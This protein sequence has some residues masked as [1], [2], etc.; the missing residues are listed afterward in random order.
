MDKKLEKLE[1]DSRARN[2]KFFNV[3]EG[4]STNDSDCVRQVIQLLNRFYPS[5][6][7]T[8]DD[9]D[10]AARIKGI[11]Q[12]AK[13][14]RVQMSVDREA[15]TITVS[16]FKKDVNQT[17]MDVKEIFR[18]AKDDEQEEK[19]K[20][21]YDKYAQ[22]GRLLEEKD[23]GTEWKKY[24]RENNCK[25][26]E[27]FQEKNKTVTIC[28]HRNQTYVI[29]FEDMVEYPTANQDNKVHVLR[30]VNVQDKHEVQMPET[31]EQHS[32]KDMTKFVP[33]QPTS[34]EFATVAT[35]FMATIGDRQMTI[36]EITR[37]QNQVLYQ[38]YQLK[39]MQM[40]TQNHAVADVCNERLLWHGTAKNATDNINNYGFNRS[41]CGKNATVHGQGVYFAKTSHYS[42]RELY[43]PKDEDGKRYMYQ[44]KI[45]VGVSCLGDQSMRVLPAR[46]GNVM[47]DSACDDV[48]DPGIY[49]I[50]LDMQ[51]YP[52]YLIT[53]KNA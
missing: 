43:S 9:V 4:R 12:V 26:E 17:L 33:L 25:I 38:Q 18:K 48:S 27:A 2:V 30:R 52:E 47:Y 49:V 40:E 11:Q 50:F 5:K 15:G 32:P 41:Y 46:D 8:T 14:K 13:N 44:S 10:K 34:L 19:R 3:F 28:N 53:F 1:T 7:W 39:K 22:W 6:A 21:I 36:V 45:L 31:W 23:K 20:A 37:I 35:N 29:D 51:A 42:A 16:G 24:S